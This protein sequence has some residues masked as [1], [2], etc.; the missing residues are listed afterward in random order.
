MT[1]VVRVILVQKIPMS[2]FFLVNPKHNATSVVHVI[3][4]WMIWMKNTQQ[5]KRSSQILKGMILIRHFFLI[6]HK[7]TAWPV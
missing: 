5:Q 4:V 7:H 1:T 2:Q 3:P 6:K